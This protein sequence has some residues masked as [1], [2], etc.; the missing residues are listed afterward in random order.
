MSEIVKLPDNQEKSNWTSTAF[1]FCVILFGLVALLSSLIPFQSA[2]PERYA[3]FLVMA[4][5]VSAVRLSLPNAIAG[6]S[7]NF[8]FMLI[9]IVA[10]SQS[11]T[12]LL[13]TGVTL[14]QVF[15]KDGFER[16]FAARAFDVAVSAASAT[17]SYLVFHAWSFPDLSI[18]V[19]LRMLLATGA[20][21]ILA[22][23]PDAVR[24]SLAGDRSIPEAWRE[25]YTWTLP[26]YLLG[27]IAASSFGFLKTDAGWPALLLTTPLIYLVY[28]HYR[29]Y[30]NR[31]DADKSHAEQMADLHLRTIEAL[32]MAIEAKDQTT[33]DHLNR[34]QTYALAVGREMRLPGPQLQALHAAA[35]LHDIGKLAV[36][37]HI[38]S[39]PGK[40]TREE[41][42]KLK[43]HPVVGAEILERVK[44]PYPVAP[45]VRHHHEKWNGGGYPDGLAGE[46]IPV[47]AR[48]LAAVDA[49]DALASERQYKKALP[50]N[51]AM[52]RIEA[53]SGISFDPRVVAILKRRYRE[54]E[55]EAQAATP[56][57]AKIDTD[58]RVENGVAPAA[59]L[60]KDSE[61][62]PAAFLSSIAAARHEAQ[63]LFELAQELGTS[64]SLDETLSV[65]AV[66]LKR[67][68]PYESIAVYVIRDHVLRPEYVSGENFRFFSSAEI[69]FGHGLSGW[70][71]E[72]RRAILNG[73]PA[74]EPGYTGSL[75]PLC[76][77]L[78]VPLE[79]VGGV[80]GVLTLY[81]SEKDAFSRDHFRVLQ[82]ITGKV[83]IC[84]ENALKYRQ[85][86]SSASTD[87]MTGL[88]NA[89]SLFLH[90]DGELARCRRLDQPLAI[91]VSDLDG[92]KQVNDRFGHLEGNKLLQQVAL[93]LKESCREY[94]CVAR[95]GGDEFVVVLPGLT[96]DTVRGMVPRLRQIVKQAGQDVLHEDVI[97]FSV[98][99]AYFPVDGDDAE[100]LLATADRRMYQFKAQQKVLKGATRGYDF[101]PMEG[102]TP[103]Y[104]RS[105]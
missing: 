71:A 18:D 66:R 54:L 87:Y 78:S 31:V 40:L 45:I 76:S 44:F 59:G 85:A 60:E 91:L 19:P 8:V 51:E 6:L 42:E 101:D 68:V 95:M 10:L 103:G 100:Q 13:V 17:S 28:R 75:T 1:S 53:E 84:V 62:K 80:V 16:T 47:G 33:H 37:E 22:T 36:P 32:A 49:F 12:V 72:N 30:L 3:A 24:M 9:G 88:L 50:L 63:S 94:D 25:S 98:G 7:V 5:A 67:I 81:R 34:V 26:Y 55:R 48:I 14:L 11:E 96:A 70:V 65:F 29:L 56:E 86:E 27:A 20:Y 90:L 39:K 46:V 97:G 43:I 58:F 74:L 15:W 4:L 57:R 41:F 52:A 89:R 99:E 73:D 93:R 83:A 23:F 38:I 61:E 64:L 21:F 104:T 77:A 2:S 69:P 82:A 92:F 79:A 35:L 105:S 102:S